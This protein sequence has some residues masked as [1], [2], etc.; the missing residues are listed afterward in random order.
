MGRWKNYGVVLL[1]I[2]KLYALSAV[3]M[4]IVFNLPRPKSLLYLLMSTIR[5]LCLTPLSIETLKCDDVVKVFGCLRR[6][7]SIGSKFM[8]NKTASNTLL[9]CEPILGVLVRKLPCPLVVHKG[10]EIRLAVR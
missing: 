3:A 4:P 9:Y 1:I 8:K 6:L 5:E 7:N 2:D 10:F